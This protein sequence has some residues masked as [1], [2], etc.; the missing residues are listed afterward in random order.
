M[1]LFAGSY[2]EK[3][4]RPNRHNQLRLRVIRRKGVGNLNLASCYWVKTFYCCGCAKSSYNARYCRGG[5]QLDFSFGGRPCGGQSA[6]PVCFPPGM[7]DGMIRALSSWGG[8][9]HPCRNKNPFVA[10]QGSRGGHSMRKI[11]QWHKKW[12]SFFSTEMNREVSIGRDRG[13]GGNT[14]V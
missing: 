12:S 6:G 4:Y 10:L 2:P 3:S 1:Q 8:G 13:R 9:I 11:L 14:V 5:D 7:G